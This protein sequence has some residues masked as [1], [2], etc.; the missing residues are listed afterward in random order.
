MFDVVSEFSNDTIGR[1]LIFEPQ[2]IMRDQ[3]FVSSFRR[4]GYYWKNEST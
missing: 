3:R 1:G 4:S 2:V